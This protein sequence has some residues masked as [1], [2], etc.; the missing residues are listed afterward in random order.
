MLILLHTSHFAL[1]RINSLLDSYLSKV[2]RASGGAD[3]YGKENRIVPAG[4]SGYG[5]VGEDEDEVENRALGKTSKKS[6]KEPLPTSVR[7]AQ[8]H[9]MQ[10]S[11][12]FSSGFASIAESFKPDTAEQFEAKARAASKLLGLVSYFIALILYCYFTL[13]CRRT[14]ERYGAAVR[15]SQR[16]CCYCHNCCNWSCSRKRRQSCW[17]HPQG[18]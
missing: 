14:A 1:N 16:R 17:Q 4:K 8:Q 2:E 11:S 10:Q 18:N 5:Q 7:E 12:N 6:K 9:A 13:A 15:Q 3:S